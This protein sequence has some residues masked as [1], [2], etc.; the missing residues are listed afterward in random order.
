MLGHSMGAIIATYFTQKY[1]ELL[2]G[3]ILSGTT[4]SS[5]AFPKPLKIVVKILSKITPKLAISPKLDP[6]ALSRDPEVVKAY[7][8]D[9]Y[10]HAEKITVRLAGEIAKHI[11]GLM[12][13]YKNLTLPLLV[14]CGSED[15]LMKVKDSK[16]DLKNVFKMEDKEIKIYNGLYHEVYNELKNDRKKV[17]KDLIDWLEKHV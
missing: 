13:A 12:D 14:Q 10:V 17:L 4:V 7:Q 5:A 2:A 6:N 1:E 3:L 15:S 8:E 9:P 16:D 11:D